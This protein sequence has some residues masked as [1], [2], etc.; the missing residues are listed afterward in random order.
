M[1]ARIEFNPIY[2]QNLLQNSN[3]IDSLIT[4]RDENNNIIE[5]WIEN[6]VED[7][8][9]ATF[10]AQVL[11]LIRQHFLLAFRENINNIELS[12]DDNN[13]HNALIRNGVT[14]NQR[15]IASIIDFKL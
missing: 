1:I 6:Q 9:E 14:Q 3:L 4:V 5:F 8:D 12:I 15:L 7:N 11:N 13:L 2:T 10:R